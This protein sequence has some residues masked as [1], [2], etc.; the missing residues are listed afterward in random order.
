MAVRWCH[1]QAVGGALGLS[2]TFQY[3]PVGMSPLLWW[4]RNLGLRA[5]CCQQGAP[6][7]GGQEFRVLTQSLPLPDHMPLGSPSP[8][9]TGSGWRRPPQCELRL[10]EDCTRT[11]CGA[12]RARPPGA[13]LPIRLE[14]GLLLQRQLKP[15]HHVSPRGVCLGGGG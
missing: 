13:S 11:R 9:V 15:M 4:G 6:R 2:T 8:P 7:M 1:Q 10:P 14:S 12:G 5:L 3:F